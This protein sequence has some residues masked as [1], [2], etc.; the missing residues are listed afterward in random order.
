MNPHEVVSQNIKRIRASRGI[1]QTDMAKSASISRQAFTDI[2]KGKTKEP[3]VSNLQAIADALDVPI[4]ALFE[5]P[6]ELNTVRFRSNSIITQKEKAKKEQYL[7]DAAYWLKNFNYLQS[8]ISD[9]KEDK[10][11][12]VFQ[13][14]GK[15]RTDRPRK[16][17]ESTRLALGLKEDEPIGDIIGLIESAGIKIRTQDFE[18]K[19][20]FGFSISESDGGPAIMV[21]NRSDISIE[22]QIFT[23]AHELAHLILHP[24]TYDPNQTEEP[25]KEEKEADIFAGYFLMPDKTFRKKLKESYGLGFVD[26]ILH[27]KCFFDVSYQAVLHRLSDMGLGS[28]GKL[29]SKFHAIYKRQ[30]GQSLTLHREP[31]PLAKPDFVE[32]YQMSLVRKAL[33]KAEI[34]VSR[35][36]E[37]LNVSLMDMRDII[38]SWAEIAV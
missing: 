28:Y 32:D 33:D 23:V 25:D 9:K 17:A 7:I 8:I 34:T 27:I 20:F 4:V 18:L 1:S 10:L 29:F 31:F 2:E 16:A 26:R 13:K 22:R 21:N 6:I 38:N 14:A 5:E 12:D 35:A 24:K 11:R 19:N 15:L 30:Y 3:K 36:A 37:I